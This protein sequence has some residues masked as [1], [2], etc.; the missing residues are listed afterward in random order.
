MRAKLFRMGEGSAASTCPEIREKG[1]IGARA[2]R[3]ARPRKRLSVESDRI[4]A[5]EG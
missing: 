4:D 2:L 5:L 1:E 3:D